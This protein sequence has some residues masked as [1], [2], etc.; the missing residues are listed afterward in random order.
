MPDDYLHY[1]K[2]KLMAECCDHFNKP[3]QLPRPVGSTEVPIFVDHI[4]PCPPHSIN[5]SAR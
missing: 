2:D 3:E 1:T 5:M 4:G